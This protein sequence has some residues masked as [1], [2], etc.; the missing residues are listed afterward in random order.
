MPSHEIPAA[1]PSP[2]LGYES[3]QVARPK[4]GRNLPLSS[5]SFPL[6]WMGGIR[7]PR[8]DRSS[9]FLFLFMPIW[10]KLC[11]HLVASPLPFLVWVLGYIVVAAWLQDEEVCPSL[12]SPQCLFR[13]VI[14]GIQLNTPR[15]TPIATQVAFFCWRTNFRQ[16]QSP[17][18]N[19]PPCAF[20][21]GISSKTLTN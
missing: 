10:G 15:G 5:P 20:Y 19:S 6:V 16:L 1:C 17:L 9:S 7:C 2:K 14:S 3:V 13:L 4:K 18:G 12:T 8:L 21:L 11:S